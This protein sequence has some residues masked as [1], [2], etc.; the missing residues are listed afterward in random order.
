MQ[1]CVVRP[2]LINPLNVGVMR[3]AFQGFANALISLPHISLAEMAAALLDQIVHGF[4]KEI[5]SNEDITEIG[6]NAL[7]K[8]NS[9]DTDVF[10]S[11][12][13]SRARLSSTP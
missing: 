5:L 13:G 8:L 10:S 11:L 3:Q 7:K 9:S 12:E 4:D 1:A 2:G 6:K